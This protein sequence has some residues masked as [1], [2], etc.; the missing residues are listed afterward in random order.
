[1]RGLAAAFGFVAHIRSRGEEAPATEAKPG[2]KARP[3]SPPLGGRAHARLDEPL[4]QPANPLGQKARELPGPASLRLRPDCLPGRRLI[5]IGI[6][7]FNCL[8]N[9]D[10]CS[11][12]TAT[13]EPSSEN[14][15]PLAIA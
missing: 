14:S 6:K 15:S 12:L 3:E 9:F 10:R 1:V 13:S 11:S 5:W 8:V 2:Q 7:S 4:S